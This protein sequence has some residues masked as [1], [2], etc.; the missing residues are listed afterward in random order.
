VYRFGTSYARAL[1]GDWQV[2]A[3]LDA[4]YANEPLVPPEQFGIGGATS[5]RGFLERERA[6]DRGHSGSLELYTPELA[7]RL[8]WNNWNLRLL[9]FYDFGRT[10][11]VE[12]QPGD[13]V[14]NGIASAGIGVRV[15]RQKNFALRFD[16]AQIVDP[17][18]TRE[19]N[20][21]RF[22]LGAVW[23]F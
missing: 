23:S 19:R 6:D 21:H 8:G 15:N 9:A 20:H 17:G 1:A 2:R 4:Q 11:R 13:E 7:T 22:N 14:H 5:V 3:R 18:G 16:L 10:S 12:P